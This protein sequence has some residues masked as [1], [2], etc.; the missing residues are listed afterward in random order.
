[1]YKLSTRHFQ[2]ENQKQVSYQ[3]K[4]S[5]E[6]RAAFI[7]SCKYQDTE[8]SKEVRAFMRSYISKNGQKKLI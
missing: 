8:G 6:L 3:I 2:L 5:S 7:K 4:M 1:M